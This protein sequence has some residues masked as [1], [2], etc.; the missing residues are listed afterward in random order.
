MGPRAVINAHKHLQNLPDVFKQQK[1]CGYCALI[2]TIFAEFVSD[3]KDLEKFM[4]WIDLT[5]FHTVTLYFW[6]VLVYAGQPAS[7]KIPGKFR[8][9]IY[10]PA[11]MLLLASSD[12]LG[13]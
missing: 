5:E 9:Q 12:H 3:F 6:K 1:Q 8:F 13:I 2:C 10:N 7:D 11:G 4:V